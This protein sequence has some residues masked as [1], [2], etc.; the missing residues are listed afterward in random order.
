MAKQRTSVSKYE[1]RYG[2]GWITAGQRL[3]EMACERIAGEK[4]L[5]LRFWNTTP[6]SSVYR[7]E[8]AHAS[9]LLKRFEAEAI[10]GA[11]EAPGGRGCRTLGAPW[12]L[13]YIVAAQEELTMST[14]RVMEA[15]VPDPVDTRQ[16]PRPMKQH[17]RSLLETIHHAESQQ[18]EDGGPA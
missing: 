10:M 1:S 2:G 5:G 6:W 7:R 9:R 15:T 11:W 18:E 3:A 4:G 12:F 16:R 14:R 13:Q 17:G 8:A